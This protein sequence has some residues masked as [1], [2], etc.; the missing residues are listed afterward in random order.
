MVR[1]IA[2]SYGRLVKKPNFF[3]C[4]KFLL[5]FLEPDHAQ[6]FNHVDLTDYK[7]ISIYPA[8]F[9]ETRTKIVPGEGCFS[10]HSSQETPGVE[11]LF[12]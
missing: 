1:H 9:V 12:L 8:I 11:K 4:S 3:L 5:S 7:N 6:L 10:Y 2:L